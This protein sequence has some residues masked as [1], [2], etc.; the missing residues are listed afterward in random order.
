MPLME[1]EAHD[2]VEG[3]KPRDLLGWRGGD[4]L[5]GRTR[6]RVMGR[7]GLSFQASRGPKGRR[8]P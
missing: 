8:T 4:W 2:E 6:V 3:A 7:M 5:S 1:H